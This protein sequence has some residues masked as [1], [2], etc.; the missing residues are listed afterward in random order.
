[1]DTDEAITAE[2][3]I[4]TLRAHEAELR[5]AGIRALSLFGSVARGDA[6]QDK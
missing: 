6:G 3:V 4:A 2:Q 5:A 1:M